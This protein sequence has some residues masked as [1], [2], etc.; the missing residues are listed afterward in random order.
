MA[1]PYRLDFGD[2][3]SVAPG[4]PANIDFLTPI[5]AKYSIPDQFVIFRG[6]KIKGPGA[7][8]MDEQLRGYA[9][10]VVALGAK[11]SLLAHCWADG[12][13]DAIANL[14]RTPGNPGVWVG[15]NLNRHIEITR[16]NLP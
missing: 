10:E 4:P 9:K 12:Q 2:Y 3:G 15:L 5:N 13:I 1:E 11:R 16:H 8:P 6:V 14:S 7:M